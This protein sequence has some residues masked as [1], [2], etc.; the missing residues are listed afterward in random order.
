MKKKYDT[1]L[2]RCF[3]QDLFAVLIFILAIISGSIYALYIKDKDSTIFLMLNNYILMDMKTGFEIEKY[4]HTFY[5]YFKQLFMIWIFG[6]FAFTLPL[7]ILA[8]F[9][10]AFSYAFTTTCVILTY[11]SKGIAAAFCIYGL[12]AVMMLA[13][14]MYLQIISFR[15]RYSKSNNLFKDHVIPVMPILA[16]SCI[17][18]LTDILATNY[19]HKLAALFL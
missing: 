2:L 4:L 7:S 3:N 12:Q 11:G 17:I 18:S 14:G 19:L 8:F 13:I 16:G 6:L 1:R 5:H 15:K 9:I 10:L